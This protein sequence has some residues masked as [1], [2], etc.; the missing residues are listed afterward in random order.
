MTGI[1]C[2]EFFFQIVPVGNYRIG[3]DTK[4]TGNFLAGFSMAEVRK[5]FEFT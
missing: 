3:G 4:L 5:D 1:S 2:L